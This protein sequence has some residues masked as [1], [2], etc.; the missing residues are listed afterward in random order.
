MHAA[1]LAFQNSFLL[2]EEGSLD[3]DIL[4]AITAA[5]LPVKDLPGMRRYWT[6]RRGYFFPA[7]AEYIDDLLTDEQFSD[8]VSIYQDAAETKQLPDESTVTE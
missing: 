1:F 2:A 7:F 8:F 3:E 5:V 4:G 6:Q